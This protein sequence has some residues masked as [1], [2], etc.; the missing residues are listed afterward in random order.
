MSINRY[1]EE[2]SFHDKRFGKNDDLRKR[3]RKYYSIAI[4]ARNKFQEL[5][6]QVCNG[7]NLLEYGCGTGNSSLEWIN[8]GAKLT[9]I[10][11]FP[12]G[13][14]KARAK[15]NSYGQKANFYVMNAE[16]TDFVDEYFDTII[17]SGILHHLD[18][19]KSYAELAR[20]LNLNG[21][22]IFLE[23]LGRNPLINLYRKFTPSLRTKNEHPLNEK[24]IKLA[25]QYFKQV[26]TYYYNLFTLFSV[27][28]KNTFLF[29][30]LFNFFQ[31]IDNF[32]FRI[33]PLRKYAWMVILC[34]NK[35][36]K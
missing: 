34:L 12:E 35:P 26:E 6:F 24:D 28:F 30:P 21:R 27:P 10:D 33:P 15:V 1:Q 5:I 16:K 7:R 14:K 19:N 36:I 8:H 2:I 3:T 4:N 11:I 23:P 18:L 32:L 17:G 9:G 25:K 22:A 13:I 31:V 29:N 20:I